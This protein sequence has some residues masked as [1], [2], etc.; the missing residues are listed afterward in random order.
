ML[1]DVLLLLALTVPAQAD[2]ARTES[3]GFEWP[4]RCKTEKNEEK[5]LGCLERFCGR[6]PPEA[7]IE[8]GAIQEVLT[9][10]DGGDT[11]LGDVGL[12]RERAEPGSL[13]R[14]RDLREKIGPRRFDARFL[15]IEDCSA[16]CRVDC[17]AL[18][19]LPTKDGMCLMWP[20]V[21]EVTLFRDGQPSIFDR[22]LDRLLGR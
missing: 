15:R 14:V 9:Y 7:C 12:G 18:E 4:E 16:R 20:L 21:R 10:L 11:V 5:K 17:A 1:D 19:R 22:V 13:K 8:W 3:T 6:R 2:Q